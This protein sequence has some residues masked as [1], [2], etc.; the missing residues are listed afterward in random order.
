MLLITYNEMDKIYDTIDQMLFKAKD[1]VPTMDELQ[2]MEN[3]IQKYYRF[4]L[5]LDETGEDTDE[6]FYERAELRRIIKDNIGFGSTTR[7]RMI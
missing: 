4:M 7:R 3:D 6:N 1:Y 2:E 5:W